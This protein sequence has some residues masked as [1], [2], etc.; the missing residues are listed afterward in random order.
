MASAWLAGHFGLSYDFQPLRA[1]PPFGPPP[2]KSDPAA[3]GDNCAP[4]W[5]VRATR[6]GDEF[7]PSILVSADAILLAAPSAR[8][9]LIGHCPQHPVPEDHAWMGFA[10]APRRGGHWGWPPVRARPA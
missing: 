1:P 9:H 10:I 7:L 5:D 2:I 3:V 4:L 6:P 8:Q